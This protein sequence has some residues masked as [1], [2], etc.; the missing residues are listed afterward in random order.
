VVRSCAIRLLSDSQRKKLKSLLVKIA[1]IPVKAAGIHHYIEDQKSELER[2]K[3]K[4]SLLE[5]RQNL[6]QYGLPLNSTF[7][8]EALSQSL[9]L[10]LEDGPNNSELAYVESHDSIDRLK[11][12]EKVVTTLNSIPFPRCLIL[13][14]DS[15]GFLAQLIPALP[16]NSTWIGAEGSE[17]VF[18]RARTRSPKVQWEMTDPISALVA[19]GGNP[20]DLILCTR[21]FSHLSPMEQVQFVRLSAKA[22]NPRGLLVL[23]IP[24]FTQEQSRTDHFWADPRNL[25]L[26]SATQL[27]N[28]LAQH[29]QIAPAVSLPASRVAILANRS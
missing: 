12:K 27:Q 8:V 24:D 4:V 29:F 26:F 21:K 7:Q 20:F 17:P 10:T 9:A 25:R 14:G 19:L 15:P 5:A 23:E 6:A 13:G 22:L 11:L 28:N 1:Q 3:S 16:Q 2:L 18:L